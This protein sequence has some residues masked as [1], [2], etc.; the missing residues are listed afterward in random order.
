MVYLNRLVHLLTVVFKLSANLVSKTLYCLIRTK[1]AIKYSFSY[2]F[3]AM[4]ELIL[5]RKVTKKHTFIFV[6]FLVPISHEGCIHIWHLVCSCPLKIKLEWKDYIDDT[7][8][9]FTVF[10][11]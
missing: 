11:V 7:L 2:S 8:D 6:C 3:I 4:S 9:N 1:G 10:N 5:L